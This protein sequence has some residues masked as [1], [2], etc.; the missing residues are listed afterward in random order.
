MFYSTQILAK[1]GPLG[2]VWLAAHMDQRLKKN[3][4]FEAN[5]AGSVGTS[6]SV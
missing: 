4:V 1:K 6:H 2:T 3:S 5:I